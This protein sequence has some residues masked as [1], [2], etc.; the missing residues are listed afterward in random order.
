MCC[1]CSFKLTKLMVLKVSA[2]WKRTERSAALSL[3]TFR[4]DPSMINEHEI[5]RETSSSQAAL[6]TSCLARLRVAWVEDATTTV[7]SEWESDVVT[8]RGPTWAPAHKH[9]LA[10]SYD[11]NT[12]R[13][14]TVLVAN[15]ENLQMPSRL[16]CK[17]TEVKIVSVM[18]GKQYTSQY[19]K[20][21]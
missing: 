3:I 5:W 4:Q 2:I 20:K 19:V 7:P 11:G 10:H 12:R 6:L 9:T 1:Q 18:D 17:Q 21:V 8:R 14:V 15:E 13:G 16:E